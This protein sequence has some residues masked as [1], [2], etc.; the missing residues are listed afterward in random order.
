MFFQHLLSGIRHLMM[1]SGWGY[2]LGLSKATAT[3]VFVGALLL[4]GAFWA[5]WFL[6][7]PG[8]R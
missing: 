6:V 1:D 4:T 3:S 7:G 5:A 8:A 2:E